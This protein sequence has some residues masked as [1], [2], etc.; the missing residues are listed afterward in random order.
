MSFMYYT[1]LSVESF[2]DILY[3]VGGAAS[4]L[5]YSGA[6]DPD[7][8]KK[9]TGNRSLS[10]DAE[11]LMMLMKLRHNFSELDLVQRFSVNQAT[12][13]HIFSTW[14]LCLYH[15]FKEINI[16]PSRVFINTYMPEEFKE[17]F[18][19]ILVII[20]ATEFPLEKPSNSDVQAATWSN[21]KN[22]N[23]LKL[24]LGVSPNRVTTFFSSLYG[25]RISDKELTQQSTLL[26]L[27]EPGD[28]I[29]PDRGFNLDSVMDLM[30]ILM[31]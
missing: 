10:P 22:H 21:Y 19:S 16:W 13:S 30:V 1:G 8:P 4:T 20:D 9:H 28:S 7:L 14:V 11:L 15:T 5:T 25:G 31:L 17:R 26:S 3:L 12:V 2:D 24:L 27:L 23:T 29:M 6:V 18:P